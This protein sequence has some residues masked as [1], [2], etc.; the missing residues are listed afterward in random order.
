MQTDL[1]AKTQDGD[2]HVRYSTGATRTAD[3]ELVR[4]DLISPI[5]L[6]AVA[7]ACA[8]GAAKYG[9]YNWE[10]GMPAS[11]LLNHAIRHIYH[12]QSGDRSEDHLGHAAW[13]ILG[14]IHSLAMWPHINDGKL[15]HAGCVAPFPDRG[16]CDE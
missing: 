16:P 3:A 5:G 12:F 14:A 9:D 15:R 6:E 13:N 1:S 11:D 10:R 8:E 4:Y 2:G 7:R